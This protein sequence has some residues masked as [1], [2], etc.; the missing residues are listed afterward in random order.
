MIDAVEK[1]IEGGT[2]FCKG[3]QS[4]VNSKRYN[5]IFKYQYQDE[6]TPKKM[7]IKLTNG[8]KVNGKFNIYIKK[9]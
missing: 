9:D 7:M 6:N 2:S 4:T 5:Y 1:T 8:N 3:S